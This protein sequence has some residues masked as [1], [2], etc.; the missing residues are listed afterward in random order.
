MPSGKFSTVPELAE[1]QDDPFNSTAPPSLPLED[2][3]GSPVLSSA[4]PVTAF[5][6]RSST[7]SKDH[8]PIKPWDGTLYPK[9]IPPA[10]NTFGLD[11]TAE[12]VGLPAGISTSATLKPIATV[13]V[14]SWIFWSAIEVIVGTSFAPVMET[15]NVALEE[16]G[17][18]ALSVTVT[19]NDSLALALSLLM[20]A[21]SGV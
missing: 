16:S 4:A 14:S 15:D 17:G 6:P 10:V 9:V 13:A 21:A 2:Q 5:F 1:S 18:V 7:E 20:A 11:E 12:T 3:T 8:R 19:W